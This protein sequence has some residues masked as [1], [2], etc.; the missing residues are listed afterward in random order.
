MIGHHIVWDAYKCDI[1]T[2]SYVA[3]IA[4]TL[5]AIVSKLDITKVG[6]QYKQFDPV[7]ATGFIL[8]AE[9]HVSI[10]TWPEH[11]FAA[12]DVFSCKEINIKKVNEIIKTM[13]KCKSLIVKD[14]ARGEN[15]EVLHLTN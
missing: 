7:G 11:G 5:N 12:I 10:H 14:I 13:M 1:E 9:S 6:E 2:I 4:K 15:I 3:D 8:L